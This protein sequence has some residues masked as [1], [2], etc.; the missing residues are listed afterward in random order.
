M[1]RFATVFAWQALIREL[2]PHGDKFKGKGNASQR[3]SLPGRI[4]T[5]CVARVMGEVTFQN[6]AVSSARQK[7]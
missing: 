7:K 2:S 1:T 5:E 3:F 6:A 4:N